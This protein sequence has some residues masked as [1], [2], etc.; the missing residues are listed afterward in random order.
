MRVTVFY[1]LMLQ[2]YINSKERLWNEI[3][4]L[5]CY[6]NISGDFSAN[7]MKKQDQIGACTTFLLNL[8]LLMLKI[9]AISTSI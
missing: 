1:L 9:L 5:F 3:K 8:V 6:G 7:S 4:H 2:K